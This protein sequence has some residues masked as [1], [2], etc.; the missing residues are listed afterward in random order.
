M[1]IAIIGL[2]HAFEKQ[3]NSLTQNKQIDIIELCDVDPE[4]TKKYNCNNNYLS[5]QSKNVIVATPPHLH[6]EMVENLLRLDKSII[7]EKPIVTSLPELAILKNISENSPFYTSL[8]FSF[9]LEIDYF[10]NNINSIPNRI[11]CYISDNYVSYKK[12]KESALCLRGSYLDETINPLSALGRMFGYNIK[13]ISCK[14]KYYP[15]DIYDYYSFSSFIIEGIETNIEVIWNN[16]ESQKY[17]DLYYDNFIIRLDSMNQAVINITTNET[18]FSGFGDRMT[19][20]YLGVYSDYIN[21]KD[22]YYTSL[23]LHEELLKGVDYEN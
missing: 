12:I 11:H 20:H 23:K 4:K 14:K 15:G 9:G 8:H 2:G 1:N 19:N 6:L 16:E 21:T 18:L 3:Y 17:I 13:F 5:L 22:N 7:L 10:I